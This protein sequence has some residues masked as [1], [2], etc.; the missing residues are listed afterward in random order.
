MDFEDWMM[1]TGC[2][3]VAVGAGMIFV[4]AGVIVL[5]ISLIGF[6]MLIAK[7]KANDGIAEQPVQE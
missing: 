7:K 2:G 3:I 6:S 4:P 5:G 1:A